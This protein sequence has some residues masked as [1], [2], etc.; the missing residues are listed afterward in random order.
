VLADRCGKR[1][2]IARHTGDV[3]AQVGP[4]QAG[5]ESTGGVQPKR[6]EP[7]GAPVALWAGAALADEVASMTST[8][9]G[10]KVKTRLPCPVPEVTTR[11]S[12]ACDRSHAL[13]PADE[14]FSRGCWV[15]S[16]RVMRGGTSPSLWQNQH[17]STVPRDVTPI[18]PGMRR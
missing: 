1:N 16:R 9:I 3:E 2:W 18:K 12:L 4:E 7:L 6:P 11:S 14:T 15:R 5:A 8:V 17:P 10:S 13:N